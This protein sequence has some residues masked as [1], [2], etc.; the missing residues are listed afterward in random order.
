MERRL[1][2]RE[3]TDEERQAACRFPVVGGYNL[4]DDPT[5]LEGASRTKEDIHLNRNRK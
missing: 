1:Q 4:P 3:A 5:L 2:L